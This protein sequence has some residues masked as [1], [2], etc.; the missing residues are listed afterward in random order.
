MEQRVE[1][2]ADAQSIVVAVS[3]SGPG[4]VNNNPANQRSRIGLGIAGL[5]NRV[6][7][8]KGTFE[9]ISRRGIGTQIRAKLPVARTEN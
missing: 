1:V 7:A 3:D 8:L 4:L 9:V 2:W 5:R 6:E